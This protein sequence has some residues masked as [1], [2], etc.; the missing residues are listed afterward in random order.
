MAFL[1]KRGKKWYAAWKDAGKNVV[2]A[3][4]ISVK[5]KAE[6]KLAQMTAD[7]MEATAKQTTNLSHALDAVRKA[8]ETLSLSARIPSIKD[9]LTDFTPG[10]KANNISNY[11]RASARFIEYLGPDALKRL[12]TLLPSSC[13][14]F[15][16][17]ELQRVSYGTVKHYKSMLTCAFMRAVRDDLIPNNPFSRVS[18]H[19]LIPV[20]EKRAT[21]REPFTREEMAYMLKTFPEQ[22]RE[23]ILVSFLTGGQRMGDVATL[24][25]EHI[26]FVSNTIS[27]AT[28]KTGKELSFPI[29]PILRSI[30]ESK[31]NNNSKFVFP[32][33]AQRY[34]RSRGS[35]SCEFTTLLKSHGIL[36]P[37]DSAQDGDRRIVSAKSFHS[38]RHTVV[39]LL[40][41]SNLFSADVARE[42]VGHDSEA[43]ERAYF[44]L[45]NS[46]KEKAFNYLLESVN[47]EGEP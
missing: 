41:T 13:R 38:I 44:T 42:V 28:S 4:G 45:D 31:L 16:L 3:T 30:L 18:L 43:V 26:D 46:I 27:F 24:Q 39:S 14:N 1:L 21:K 5:G 6:Q 10:G 37:K 15:L 32:A 8:A 34:N 40:R 17:D 9:Y 19:K 29:H 23:L 22:W 36:T 47:K 7:A 2:K 25:W 12:D 11:R 33:M 20:G 35:L